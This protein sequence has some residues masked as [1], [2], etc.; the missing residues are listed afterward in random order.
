[1]KKVL[2]PIA[3]I[4]MALA[5]LAAVELVVRWRT[6]HPT[7]FYGGEHIASWRNGMMVYAPDTEIVL[8]PAMFGGYRIRAN[9]L[10][11]R[12]TSRG[13]R[14]AIAKDRRL[15]V[16]ALGD[17]WTDSFNVA[18][19]DTYPAQLQR[20]LDRRFP[21]RFE[22]INVAFGGGSIRKH[23]ERLVAFSDLAPDIVVIDFCANDLLDD[24]EWGD[25]AEVTRARN[26]FSLRHGR[27]DWLKSV[28]Y[29]RTA[30]G[31]WLVR[32]RV[33][34][35]IRDRV[36]RHAHATSVDERLAIYRQEMRAL[37]D[38]VHAPKLSAHFEERFRI[39]FEIFDELLGF[40]EARGI[41]T[42]LWSTPEYDEVHDARSPR[43]YVRHLRRY[44]ERRGIPF[45]DPLVLFAESV[46]T[47]PEIELYG[48]APVDFHPSA[49]GY[50]LIARALADEVVRQAD[51][52]Q[53]GESRPA[54]RRIGVVSTTVPMGR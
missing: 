44:A 36:A 2:F 45:V 5:L 6:G 11:F 20:E 35:T 23:L 26:P 41:R 31:E 22:V 32:E 14:I 17:S 34:R 40:A 49:A 37:E 38:L 51:A 1:M 16:F 25:H 12:P 33:D 7:G 28:F 8:H 10:G 30:I 21:E 50:G 13:Q 15:R 54:R 39:Y 3:S 46:R 18:D 52:L 19:E 4:A 43:T 48:F 24:L 53:G 9:H 42:I 47:H 29:G 27:L